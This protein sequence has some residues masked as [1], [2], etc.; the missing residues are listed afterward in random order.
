VLWLDTIKFD[1]PKMDVVD[2]IVFASIL[3][4]SRVE[5]VET[6]PLIFA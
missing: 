4:L 3:T 5:K 1:W 2:A 6:D